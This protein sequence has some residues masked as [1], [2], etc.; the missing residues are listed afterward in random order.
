MAIESKSLPE[1]E[2]VLLIL[3]VSPHVWQAQVTSYPQLIG[4]LPECDI[5]IP[6]R[7]THVS[8]QHALI[9]NDGNGIWIQDL[10]SLGGSQLNGIPLV[11]DVQTRAIIGD[12]LSLSGLELYIVSSD[13]EILHGEP[14]ETGSDSQLATTGLRLGMRRM[15]DS[16][17]DA[18]LRCLSAAELEVVRWICRGLTTF[19]EIGKRLFRSPHTV[20]TQLGSVYRKLD[21]HSRDELVSW[22]KRCEI[23]W[24]QPSLSK[25]FQF[26]LSEESR[27]ESSDSVLSGS[28]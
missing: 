27:P 13:A 2:A 7:Y 12:R 23:S 15:I 11:P 1:N 17:D 19:D 18:R 14:G 5:V 28:P 3:N 9:G 26:H 4:R 16:M 8:R 20:R 24:T 6:G 21:V 25:D 10:G 22:F